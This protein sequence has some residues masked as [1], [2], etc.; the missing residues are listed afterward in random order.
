MKLP[1]PSPNGHRGLV[2][3]LTAAAA[4]AAILTWSYWGRSSGDLDNFVLLW[5]RFILQHGRWA[6]LGQNFAN[7]TPPYLYLLSLASLLDG[8]VEP[9]A[10]I[11]LISVLF[12]LLASS[13]VY[14][15]SRLCGR[16]RPAAA[17]V[18]ALFF[19][20]PEEVLNS[21]VWGQ[22]DIIYTSFLL[23]FAAGMLRGR[24]WWACAALGTAFA[25]KMQALFIAPLV[26]ALLATKRLRIWHLLSSA[27]AF[28]GLMTPAALAGRPWR[29]ILGIY[30]DQA[31]TY[32]DL[33]MNAPNPYAWLQDRLPDEWF[34][35]AAKIGMATAATGCL[36][37]TA[38]FVQRCY[39]TR[40]TALPPTLFLGAATL[41]LTMAPYLLP[42]M[43]E[44]Y[45]FPAGAFALCCAVAFPAAGVT[46]I[47]L[48][49]AA[50]L[51]YYEFLFDDSL[52]LASWAAFPTTLSLGWGL[53]I[54]RKVPAEAA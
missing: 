51:T 26:L 1:P 45:F 14:R 49:I 32:T 15:L 24:P 5:Y 17:A 50:I 42:K 43:H 34:D 35:S 3:L 25:F 46:A 48:Q 12:A 29:D 6:A 8:V 31:G 7:Y 19:C 13:A 9:L 53:W 28:M 41:S 39:R 38:W 40:P 52:D 10:A 30:L 4:Q 54:F 23:L 44:R 47:G 27:A 2:L 18:A 36:I 33:S 16:D 22:C 21:A 37:L 11:K 20:L